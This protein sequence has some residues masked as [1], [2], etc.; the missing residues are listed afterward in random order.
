M[1]SLDGYHLDLEQVYA[2]SEQGASVRIDADAL[3]RMHVSR[4]LVLEKACSQE[5]FYG[6]NTA[7]G[8]NKD[9]AVS[10]ENFSTFNQNLIYSHAV[11]LGETLS[12][13]EV[14]AALL[15]KANSL[16]K[17]YTGAN[18]AIVKRIIDFLNHGIS[19]RLYRQGSIGQGDI[20][21]MSGLGLALIGEGEANYQGKFQPVADILKVLKLPPLKLGVR[22]GLAIVSSNAISLAR[23]SFI[24]R[25]LSDLLDQADL[26]Y[27]FSLEGLAGNVSPFDPKLI[28]LR[29]DPFLDKLAS[30]YQALLKGSYLYQRPA[31]TMQDPLSY[32]NAPL[33]HG[34]AQRVYSSLVDQLA[35]EFLAVD[36]NPIVDLDRQQIFSTACYDTTQLA[37]IVETMTSALCQI[38]QASSQRILKLSD[39]RF[40][41]L[42]RFLKSSDCAYFGL[43]TLQK[44]MASLYVDLV[45]AKQNV[46]TVNLSLSGGVED[47]ANNLPALLDACQTLL[48]RLE[49]LLILEAI[50][51]C[52][53]LSVRMR[54]ESQLSLGEATAKLYQTLHDQIGD[55][56]DN[57]LLSDKVAQV[58]DLWASGCFS[59]TQ[60]RI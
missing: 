26:V 36:D 3:E 33:V 7:L 46:S 38:G 5:A 4:Q 30:R 47:F 56:T 1:L 27:C 37:L 13:R 60:S 2:I 34:A 29:R 18:P 28:G 44:T 31:K 40:T 8:Q 42:T 49:M 45:H 55:L 19:P 51:A 52:Q 59:Q 9:Q 11:G 6:V 24:C 20:G 43:Q 50:Y 57:T 53:A 35:L 17:G 54:E 58:K 25:R 16:L 15:I 22:D 12:E 14:R 48:D 21:L 39:P 41:Y 32:R 23:L 10:V